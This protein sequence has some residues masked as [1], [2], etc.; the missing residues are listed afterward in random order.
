VFLLGV[1]T[2]RVGENAAIA[3]MIAGLS[4]MIYVKF[5]TH[6]AWTWYVLIGTSITFAS[7][8]FASLFFKEKNN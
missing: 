6:I 7:G 8:A 2:R 3:G 4:S 5:G 1:L